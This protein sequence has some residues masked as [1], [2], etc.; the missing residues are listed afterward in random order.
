VSSPVP[1]T[2]PIGRLSTRVAAVLAVLLVAAGLAAWRQV[3]PVPRPADAPSGAFSA[4]RAFPVLEELVG[5]GLPHPNGSPQNDVVRERILTAFRRIGYRPEVQE[6]TVERRGRPFTVRNVVA[7]LAGDGAAPPG[8]DRSTV[9]LMSHYDSVP[10]GPGASDDGLSVAITLEVARLLRNDPPLRN[11]VLFLVTDAEEY[12]MLGARAFVAEHPRAAGI[13]VV[14]NLE[15]RGTSGPSLMF[16]TGTGTAWLAARMAGRLRHPATSSLMAAIYHL[17]PNDT[18]LT[19]F[20][21]SGHTGYNFAFI[22]DDQNY[23]TPRDDL[24]HVDRRS[25][26]HQGEN[27]LALVRSLA[28]ADLSALPE[29]GEAVW[30]DFLG[31]FLVWWPLPLTLPLGLL[32]LALSAWLLLRLQRRGGLSLGRALAGLGLALLLI[33]LSFGAA[34]LFAVAARRA[35]WIVGSEASNP[36]AVVSGF[37]L[38]ALLGILAGTWLIGRWERG[39]GPAGLAWGIGAL[40]ALL[41]LVAVLF[42]PMGSYLLLV[43]ALL[44]ALTGLVA[45]LTPPGDPALDTALHRAALAT[46]FL[47]ACLW[48]P[49]EFL[50]YQGLGLAP[51]WFT[52][53]RAALVSVLAAPLLLPAG[54]TPTSPPEP[55]AAA[56]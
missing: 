24:A 51:T 15:A 35:G 47:A 17:M 48:L 29:A 43:P 7:R 34:R 13:G 56:A 5:D 54:R 40:W 14:V 1:S 41:A 22:G 26:Q 25:F 44:A 52:A 53:L 23:H 9:L 10:D 37:W 2:L 55:P 20:L 30:F 16:E 19:V 8:S 33:G 18:D 4:E 6:A 3:P 28:A 45:S 42:F 46:L 27:A 38:A 31:S 12:G 21:Q 50:F 11:N 49:Y 32:A 39:P 36:V